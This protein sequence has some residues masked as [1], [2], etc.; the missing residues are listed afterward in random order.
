MTRK[1]Q[2]MIFVVSGLAALGLA[3]ALVLTALSDNITFF[4][5]P[6]EVV[7]GNVPPN[8]RPFRIGG[9]VAEGSVQRKSAD[10]IEFTVTDTMNVVHVTYTGL[11]PNLFKEGQGVVAEGKL[12]ATGKF[13][14]SQV[15]AKHDE[16]YMPKEVVDALKAAGEWKGQ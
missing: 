16:T 7:A 1:K 14:A 15:L 6:S 11:V 3:A 10:T 2:R 12:D 4:R 5:S 9:L 13:V 8:N